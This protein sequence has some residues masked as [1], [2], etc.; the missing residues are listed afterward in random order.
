MKRKELLL[1][2]ILVMIMF[3]ILPFVECVFFDLL[4][5]MG[6]KLFPYGD[7]YYFY[8][9]NAKLMITFSLF[10]I[11]YRLIIHLRNRWF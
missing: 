1:N 11:L 5:N 2:I 10:F 9:Q 3:L 4:S 8:K 6:L 7:F